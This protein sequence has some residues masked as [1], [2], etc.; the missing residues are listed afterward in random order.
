MAARTLSI[1]I[2]YIFLLSSC[3][4]SEVEIGSG[5]FEF[6]EQ[7]RRFAAIMD[8]RLQKVWKPT[9]IESRVYLRGPIAIVPL[10][11][12]DTDWGAA[13][14]RSVTE[15]VWETRLGALQPGKI[16]YVELNKTPI[17]IQDIPIN[18]KDFTIA[19]EPSLEKCAA[20]VLGEL[21]GASE[22]RT[23]IRIELL[24]IFGAQGQ[25]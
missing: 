24:K 14:T 17:F 9:G 2:T 6:S 21:V 8:L 1:L 7:G 12:S 19:G 25:P 5:S 4:Q 15:G 16:Y 23:A 13:F 20:R 10:Q 18:F 11:T 3:S 22:S